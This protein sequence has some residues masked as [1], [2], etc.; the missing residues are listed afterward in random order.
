MDEDKT[1][2]LVRTSKLVKEVERFLCVTF[3]GF[4][5]NMCRV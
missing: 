4:Y 5:D 1:E 3:F 2:T